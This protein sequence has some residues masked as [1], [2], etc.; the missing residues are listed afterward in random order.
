MST[1]L[2]GYGG[3]DRSRPSKIAS[4]RSH[5][6][7]PNRVFRERRDNRRSDFGRRMPARRARRR[8]E[9][10]QYVH[11][12][13]RKNILFLSLPEN[14]IWPDPALFYGQL[15]VG[16]HPGDLLWGVGAM[17]ALYQAAVEVR[18]DQLREIVHVFAQE[19]PA[20]EA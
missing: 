20:A 18:S 16:E 15:D 5:G 9:A 1:R 4:G 14:P 13:W 6:T 17:S 12:G 3:G 7:G 8:D 10:E 2:C 19:C 11:G